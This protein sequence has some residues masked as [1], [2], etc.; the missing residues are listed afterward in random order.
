MVSALTIA[1]A[2]MSQEPEATITWEGQPPGFFRDAF[3]AHDAWGEPL[4]SRRGPPAERW[5]FYVWSGT[6]LWLAIEVDGAPEGE[7]LC[8]LWPDPNGE[9]ASEKCQLLPSG[10]ARLSF[11]GPENWSWPEGPYVARLFIEADEGGSDR[12]LLGEVHYALGEMPMD[13]APPLDANGEIPTFPWPPPQPTTQMVLEATLLAAGA[14][15][16]GGVADR[17]TTVLGNLGYSEHGF[18]AVPGGFALATRLEQIEFDGTP[19]PEPLRWSSALPPRELFSLSD[20]VRAL[21]TAP[22]G[23][24]RVIVFV[25]ND[26]AFAAS[27]ETVSGEEALAWIGAGLNR[28]PDSIADRPFTERHAGTAMI[29]QFHRVGHEQEPIANPDGAETAARQLERS[30]ILTALGQ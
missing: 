3:F 30:G 4:R 22:E 7:K 27:G 10:P 18:Y 6:P 1:S 9:T 12:E 11:P 21:F 19:K 29:Y 24:Y 8:V 25:V 14:T 23:H 26:Q 5:G 16:L 2:A 20:F 28:L 17:L 13:A 15:T